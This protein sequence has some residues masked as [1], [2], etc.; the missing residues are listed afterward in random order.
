MS[1]KK[2]MDNA[3]VKNNHYKLISVDYVNKTL[4]Q[5]LCRKNIKNGFG[6]AKIWPFNAQLMDDNIKHQKHVNSFTPTK[7]ETQ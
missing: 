4:D 6:G 3:I 5:S 1:F 7:K 2:E